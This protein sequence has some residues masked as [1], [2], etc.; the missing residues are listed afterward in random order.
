[1]QGIECVSFSLCEELL[2]NERGFSERYF[3]Q[4]ASTQ[5]SLMSRT[6]FRVGRIGLLHHTTLPVIYFP[7]RVHPE[8]FLSCI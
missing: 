2:G 5:M 3:F 4:H 1:M 7:T 6:G 8:V